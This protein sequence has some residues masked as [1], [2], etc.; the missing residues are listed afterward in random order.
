MSESNVKQ[1]R[2]LFKFQTFVKII[3]F[4]E[5]VGMYVPTLPDV[6]MNYSFVKKIG[7][8]F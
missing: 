7:K 6:K 8:P 5:K 2:Q 3:C 1:N 4:K